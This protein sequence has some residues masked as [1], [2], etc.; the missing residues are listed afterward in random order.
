MGLNEPRVKNVARSDG[1]AAL[2]WLRRSDNPDLLG[3][4]FLYTITLDGAEMRFEVTIG[5]RTR[6][7]AGRKAEAEGV[8]LLTRPF[9]EQEA[10]FADYV[11]RNG[12]HFQI[13]TLEPAQ[14][15]PLP[16]DIIPVRDTLLSLVAELKSSYRRNREDCSIFEAGCCKDNINFRPYDVDPKYY[17]EIF[18]RKFLTYGDTN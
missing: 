17:V 10:Y 11:E 3:N 5:E 16:A 6:L 9:A 2:L 13:L 1:T 14:G 8:N 15:G 12:R 7:F 4:V 18:P